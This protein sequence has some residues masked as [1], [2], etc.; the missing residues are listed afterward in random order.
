MK[1]PG[2]TDEEAG[3]WLAGP[4]IARLATINRAGTPR[5][6]ALWYL[7]EED[8]SITLDT[9]EDNVHVAN[10]RR[11]PRVA[12]LIDSSEAPYKSV[13]LNGEADIADDA[14]TAEEI[15]RL[16]ARYLGGREAATDYGRM[17]VGGGKRVT[18]R[19]TPQRTR[20]VDMAK[21]G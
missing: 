20:T 1:M 17:L 15:G 2:L 12:L 16:F 9:Y 6:T 7:A 8:G 19:L 13:H 21:L 14:T 3:Q 10:I 5:V 4:N 11:D 18:I